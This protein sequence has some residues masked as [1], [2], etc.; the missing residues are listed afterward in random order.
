MYGRGFGGSIS[1]SLCVR[2]RVCTQTKFTTQNWLTGVFV[3]GLHIQYVQWEDDEWGHRARWMNWYTN[4]NKEGGKREGG[5]GKFKDELHLKH[6]IHL[7]GSSLGGCT[8]RS[9]D[10]CSSSA[11]SKIS[12]P[13][14]QTHIIMFSFQTPWY[15]YRALCLVHTCYKP[16]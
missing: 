11:H 16:Q 6:C 15:T 1:R 2:V 8:A 12:L 13:I 14:R 5:R 10:T 4:K 7:T 9:S 3:Q